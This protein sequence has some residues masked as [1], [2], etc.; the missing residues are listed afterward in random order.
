MALWISAN[1]ISLI[2]WP[3]YVNSIKFDQAH[4]QYLELN[5]ITQIYEPA[6]SPLASMFLIPILFAKEIGSILFFVSED[7]NQFILLAIEIIL[8]ALLIFLHYKKH[9]DFSKDEM[10]EYE[11]MI[12]S[13]IGLL[14]V[15]GGPLYLIIRYYLDIN[16]PPLLA[17]MYSLFFG[18]IIFSLVTYFEIKPK[19]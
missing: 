5:P 18:I 1:I 2:L 16:I 10:K 19:K 6:E 7:K 4:S 13:K 14:P 15:G 11:K 17:L 12:N 9:K 8:I 3:D